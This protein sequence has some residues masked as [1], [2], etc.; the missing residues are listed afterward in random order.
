[1]NDTLNGKSNDELYKES[2]RQRE[3]ERRVRESKHECTALDA[4]RN[5]S[6]DPTEKASFDAEFSSAAKRLK[7]RESKLDSYCEETGRKKLVDRVQVEGYNKSVSGKTVAA[8]KAKPAVEVA[9][10][11]LAKTPDGQQTKATV[12]LLERSA[13]RGVS[14]DAIN[15]AISSPLHVKPVKYD[16]KGRPSKQYIG[17]D[18]TVSV[19]PDTGVVTSTWVTGSKTRKKYQ[20]E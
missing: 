19:N 17:K 3:L 7:Q 20:K 6:K 1:M 15:D 14:K 4:A 16:E 5:A 11:S 13:E 9:Q 8:A 10:R 2:Q 18:A 12:H